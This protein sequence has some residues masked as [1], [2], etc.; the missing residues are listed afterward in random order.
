MSLYS[1]GMGSRSTSVGRAVR[2]IRATYGI[3][4][5]FEH[6]RQAGWLTAPEI[7]AQLR[8]H[9]TTAKRF[10]A[11]GVLRLRA[12]D[13]GLILF[14]PLTGPLPMAQPGKRYRDRRRFPQCA[15]MMRTEMQCEAWT[16]SFDWPVELA[17]WRFRSGRPSPRRCA[18]GRARSGRTPSR[19]SSTGRAP[20][21]REPRPGPEHI[22][23][24]LPIQS[25]IRWVNVASG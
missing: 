14:E 16:L 19:R 17:R 7:A 4:S 24:W 23:T 21:A 22:R 9:F 2:N 13:R 3:A 12:D 10:A 18:A 20:P 5:L 6:L 25:G 11:E 8:V 1:A 15:S